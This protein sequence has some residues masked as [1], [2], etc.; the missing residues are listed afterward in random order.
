MWD[1]L[2]MKYYL[3][4]MCNGKNNLNESIYY[5]LPE[6]INKK[7]FEEFKLFMPSP[8]E[9]LDNLKGYKETLIERSKNERDILFENIEKFLLSSTD[10]N[11][12]IIECINPGSLTPI[13]IQG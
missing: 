10:N 13:K 12:N 11:G 9:L 8:T 7:V 5:A 1:N 4:Y 3:M 6:E 2:K